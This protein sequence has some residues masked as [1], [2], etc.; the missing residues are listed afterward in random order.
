MSKD[1]GRILI[2]DTTLRDGEQSPGASLNLEEKLAIAHQLARLGVDVIEAG[3][4]FASH[5]DFKAVNK[6][7]EV[8]GG[9]NGPII[10][11][12]ARASTNDIKACYEAI[13]PAPRKRI[14]TFIAT[15]DIHLKH[16][17]RKSRKDV[18][19]IVPEMVSYAK[20]LVEDIEFSCED[21]SRSDPEFLYEVIQLAIK[22]GATTINI[23]DTV[24]F[25]TPSEFG[26]LIFDINKNVPNIDEA[27]ISVHG[28]NDLG[29]AV[30]NFLEATKNG[31]RQLECTINGI[32]ERAG[33]ASLEELVMALHVR[34]SFFN[35]FLGRSSDSPTPLTAIRT[36]EITKT[37]RLVSNL[38]GMNVQP[39]KAIVGANA[40][41]HESGIHQDGVLKNRLTY[42]IID[43]K[44]VG[45]NDNKISLGK[46]SGRSAVR[47]RLEEMGY[48]LSREDLN[49]AFARFKDL[50]D[51]KREITDRD[52]E[53]IVSEQVQLPESKF[54]LSHVQVSCGSTSKPTATVT[55]INTEEHTENTAVEIGTGPVDAVCKALNALAKVP[56]ELIEFSV[57]S[58]TEGIDAL[59]EVTIRIRNKNKIYSGHSADTDV[60][61][62][63]AN[64][65]V[66]ALNRLVF[67][68][69]KNSIHPQF[70]N[71][72]NSENNLISN[73]E[74]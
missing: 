16:K 10:C 72:E 34:K 35:S 54:Q 30:A 74:N 63:A 46:L 2:F 1:P 50:A 42:E 48:D 3:F 51:R 64:A 6:I 59:G 15:S 19:S 26:S 44:T 11:G 73:S 29:L 22:S 38:T 40:F 20:S 5:G 43:A 13:S 39:N 23:P 18:L 25:T 28:H 17:L 66:N 52:L 56:N 57:K 61:V 36:E 12:L 37:S 70:D 21:A 47:A 45:L 4:P 58:V 67:S 32:G 14:H 27:I 71:L 55:L 49:D 53:A 68:E 41:A 31:A 69:K 8:V 65:F 62:A 9:E 7:S 60:V 33:N 24:G